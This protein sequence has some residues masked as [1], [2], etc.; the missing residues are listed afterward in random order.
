VHHAL[1]LAG[2]AGGVEK[3]DD[4][5]R[6]RP[7]G[8]EHRPGIRVLLQPG[9]QQRR[10]EIVADDEQVLQLRQGR[11]E[12]PRHRRM[13][14]PPE[15]ARRHQR[16]C[17]REIEHEGELALAEDRHQRIGTDAKAQ[18]GDVQA[19]ELPPVGKLE[20]QHVSAPE[21]V[22]MKAE[23]HPVGQPL[24]LAPGEG[25]LAAVLHPPGDHRNGVRLARHRL[26]ETVEQGAV[27][28]VAF[29]AVLLAP[30]GGQDRIEDHRCRRTA[31]N[32]IFRIVESFPECRA[33]RLTRRRGAA[34]SRPLSPR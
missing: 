2:R 33:A 24:Q 12:L 30:P 4:L 17:V 34:R 25:R 9:V 31:L 11:A 6:F 29:G 15:D 20:G 23:R 22:R 19:V 16:L 5:V 8:G 27:A 7:A 10:L 26:V 18:A 21:P 1:G 14:V 32:G 3:L 13:V 28:P